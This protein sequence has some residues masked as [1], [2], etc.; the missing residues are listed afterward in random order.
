MLITAAVVRNYH[1]ESAEFTSFD[2]VTKIE[3]SS[4]SFEQPV[5]RE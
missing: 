2:L 3:H 5:I 4:T 1:K